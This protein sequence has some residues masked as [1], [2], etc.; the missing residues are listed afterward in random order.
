M[1]ENDNFPEVV[2]KT[3]EELAAQKKR[4]MWLGLALGGFVVLI[5]VISAFRFIDNLASGAG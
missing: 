1:T 5:G 4:N 3:P 2:A